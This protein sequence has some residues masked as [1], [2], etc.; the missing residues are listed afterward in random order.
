MMYVN[1]GRTSAATKKRADNNY[2][3]TINVFQRAGFMVA[4]EKSDKLGDSA[5]RKE[6]LGFII[7]TCD[8]TVHLPEQKLRRVLDISSN[9]L[10]R[11]RHKVR[12]VASLVGKLVSLEPALGR[13]IL[14]GTHLATIAIVAVTDGWMQTR[15][16]VI[17]GISSS[18]WTMIFSRHYTMYG[19]R[20]EVGTDAPSA[21]GIPV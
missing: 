20:Q 15:K 4:V 14:V 10:R 12:D 7:D 1:D 6:Y 8:M 5:Q 16:E 11:R 17:R 2:A 19:L 21:V 18:T 13:L 9:F 3:I